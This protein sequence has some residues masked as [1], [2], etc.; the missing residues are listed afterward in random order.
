MKFKRKIVSSNLNLD[1]LKIINQ[2]KVRKLKNM[3]K[4]KK[5]NQKYKL[6]KL[7]KKTIEILIFKNRKFKN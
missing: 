1:S 4:F 5:M 6:W 2:K 7:L 3:I